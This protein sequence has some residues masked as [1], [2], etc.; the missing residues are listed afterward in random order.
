MKRAGLIFLSTTLLL[1]G[2]HNAATGAGTGTVAGASTGAI[3]GG[4]IGGPVGMLGG[5]VIGAPVG[6][7]AGGVT[8]AMLDVGE[9]ARPNQTTPET[10]KKVEASQPLSLEDVE[11]LAK[12]GVKEELIIGRLHETNSHFDLKSADLVRLKNN[13]V[14]EGIINSMFDMVQ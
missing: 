13:G 10:L 3:I 12:A 7:I 9:K 6:A 14:S 8:G 4:L 1:T 5:M 11:N 2:C